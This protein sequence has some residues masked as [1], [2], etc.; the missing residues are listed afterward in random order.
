M[1]FVLTSC[2]LIRYSVQDVVEI[3]YRSTVYVET[4]GGNCSGF[5]I[6]YDIVVTAGHCILDQKAIFMYFGD[7]QL[8]G[9]VLVDDDKRDIAIIRTIERIPGIVPV[10]TNESVI[11]PGEKLIATGFPFYSGKEITFNIGYFQGYAD[12]G[13]IATDVCL[14]GNSGGPVFDELGQVIGVCSRI[15]PLL[16]IFDGF[17]HTHKDINILVPIKYVREMIK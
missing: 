7:T 13:L 10:L 1:S 14:R 6:D 11:K 4:A 12:V 15:A 2:S 16:D 3:G 8:I 5:A 17:H 9:E